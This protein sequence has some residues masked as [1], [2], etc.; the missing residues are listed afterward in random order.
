MI[1]VGRVLADEPALCAGK[2]DHRETFAPDQKVAPRMW[3][4]TYESRV[5]GEPLIVVTEGAS[6]RDP[7]PRKLFG[8]FIRRVPRPRFFIAMPSV[9]RN[10]PKRST[11]SESTYS[12]M[13]FMNEFPTDAVCLEHLW[14]SR[15]APDGAHAECA[16]CARIRKFHKDRSRPSWSCDSCGHRIH[17]LAGTIFKKSVTSL[18]LWFYAMYLMTSTR[19]GISAKQLEREIG[20]GYKTAWRMCNLIRNHLME[21]DASA[22]LTGSVEADETA[23]G[24]RPTASMTRGMR[25]PKRRRSP[26][27]AR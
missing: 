14:R 11:A 8:K 25:W 15:F 21:Q 5:G 4:K 24:G 18:H 13:E 17:P 10:N 26:S 20:V 9:D 27:S 12:L 7:V 6:L 23:Y 1:H 3:V 22:Q 19:C 16:K 2:S